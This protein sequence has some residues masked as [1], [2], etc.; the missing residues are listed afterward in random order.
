MP[1][2]M[3][4][5]EV[6]KDAVQ[7]AC[8]A[9]SLHNSQPWE[10]VY[11][12]GRLDL[13]LDNSR[14][15]LS[16]RSGRE[17]LISCGVVLDHLR[18]AMAAAG[19][20]ARIHRFPNANNLNH[21][22]SVNFAAMDQVTE[23][24]RRR[25]GAI[26]LRRTDRLPFMGPTDWELFEPKLRHA[27]DGSSVRLDVMS[28]DLRPQLVEA[29]QLAESLRF[30]DSS[31]HSELDWWAA[32]FEFSEGIPRSSRI[33]AD[34]SERVD[35]GRLF[36]LTR[37]GERR[38]EVP[39]DH[40]KVLLLSTDDDSRADALASGEALS[41]VLLECTMAGLATCP[42]THITEVRASRE[43]VGALLDH[44]AVPQVLIRVG[45]APAMEEVPPA[46]P[47]RPL[48]EVLHMLA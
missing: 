41:A 43:L 6:I 26:L 28:D 30:Y 48:D 34:E 46:T 38:P 15:M 18:V 32:P 12:D 8:H 35:I 5:T 9:P 19:W 16:D 2:T 24:D 22:A 7:L 4:E 31:Y 44:D 23:G 40:S 37:H 36:P 33:S 27:V 20:R 47:R 3:V 1:A 25:A 17:A 11:R 42:V 39:E 21:L 13:F 14:A 10:W 45:V 29:S